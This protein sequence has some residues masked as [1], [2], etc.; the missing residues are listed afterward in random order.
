[1]ASVTHPY[2]PRNPGHNYYEPGIYLITLVVTEREPRL[3]RLNDN[4]SEPGVLHTPTGDIVHEEWEKTAT[5]QTSKGRQI[6]TLCQ[7]CMPDHWHGVIHVKERM[8]KSLGYVIQCFKSACTARWRREVTHYVEQ[9]SSFPPPNATKGAA[10]GATKGATTSEPSLV[11]R[12][13]H[14]SQ[15][16]RRAYYATRPLIERPLFDDDYDDTICFPYAIDPA[17]HERHKAAMINYVHDNPRRAMFRRL[18]PQ[19]MQRQLHVII[20][21]TDYAAFGNLFLLRWAKKVQ[22]FCHRKA[23][24]GML[25]EQERTAAGYNQGQY[26]PDFISTVPYEKTEAFRNEAR[27]WKRMVMEGATVIVTPGISE[28]EKQIKNRCIEK[29]YPLIHLQKEPIGR[30][31]KPEQSRFEACVQG[32]LLILSPWHPEDMGDVKGVPS[33][34]DYSIFHNLNT[35][36]AHICLFDGEAR[37]VRR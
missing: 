13:Q 19:F 37:I 8:D 11:R 1:M 9:T 35:L 15:N 3:G 25:T 18:Y 32:R 24:Y 7:V 29:G 26:S 6:E 30:Y 12:L 2:R 4:I 28:G 22:V 34:T 31:W 36:A 23:R 27:Q 5:I 14:W 10:P 33:T 16:Q 20:D 21:G 17:E